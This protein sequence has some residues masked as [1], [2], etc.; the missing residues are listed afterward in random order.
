MMFLTHMTIA[1]FLGLLKIR[2][3][4]LPINNYVFLAIVV[5]A[6]L[7]PDIDSDSFISKKLRLRFLRHFFKHRGFFHSIIPMIILMII[8]FLITGNPYYSLA[9]LIGFGS[10]LIFDSFTKGGIAFFWPH[11]LRIRGRLKVGGLFDWALFLLFVVLDVLLIF[12]IV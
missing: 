1:L 6:S 11:K 4:P 8:V 2:L 3:I 5:F 9:V 10:H 7:L 12:I